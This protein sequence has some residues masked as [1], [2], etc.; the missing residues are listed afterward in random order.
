[1]CC[2]MSI[3]KG[4]KWSSLGCAGKI[5]INAKTL[6]GEEG[7]SISMTSCHTLSSDK[8]EAADESKP[9]SITNYEL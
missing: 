1:M 4:Q 6:R 9:E 5:T 7:W 3:R 2:C 8:H